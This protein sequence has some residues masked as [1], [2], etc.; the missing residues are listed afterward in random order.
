MGN[1]EQIQVSFCFN[2]QTEYQCQLHEEFK[3]RGKDS[4][5]EEQELLISY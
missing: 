1:M 5:G 4:E 3:A 2:P